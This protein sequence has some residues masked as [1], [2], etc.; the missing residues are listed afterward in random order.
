LL[1]EDEQWPGNKPGE[2]KQKLG[3]VTAV[4]TD[5]DGN[6]VIFHRA[7]RQWQAE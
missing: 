7:S 1:E 3:Q 2:Q 6:V 5:K 4:D